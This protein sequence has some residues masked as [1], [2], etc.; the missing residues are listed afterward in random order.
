MIYLLLLFALPD[1]RGYNHGRRDPSY[2][3]SVWPV[4]FKFAIG[5]MQEANRPRVGANDHLIREEYDPLIKIVS[6]NPKT[7][8]KYNVGENL[9]IILS[10]NRVNYF[11][12]YDVKLS[13]TCGSGL[14]HVVF[15]DT[16]HR[17]FKYEY[18]FWN[19]FVSTATFERDVQLTHNMVGTCTLK[20]SITC[21]IWNSKCGKT[22]KFVTFKVKEK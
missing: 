14:K 18:S 20:L 16:L 19:M 4:V 6:P 8:E 17:L 10:S 13:V 22:K 12:T 3:Q 21:K 2:Q 11:S 7:Q 5:T 9:K 15:K 1:R